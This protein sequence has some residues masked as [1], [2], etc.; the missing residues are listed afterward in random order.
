MFN[1]NEDFNC[2][3]LTTSQ[4][5]EYT[6]LSRRTAV[7]FANEAGATKKISSRKNLYDRRLIDEA[8]DKL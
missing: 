2:K 5:C 4:L 1:R 8:L 3:W 6:K 7:R